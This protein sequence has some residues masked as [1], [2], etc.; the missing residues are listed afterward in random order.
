MWEL[1]N[2]QYCFNL[3]GSDFSKMGCPGMMLV[4][5]EF[6]SYKD[7]QGITFNQSSNVIKTLCF[8]AISLKKEDKD[9]GN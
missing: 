6:S 2:Y 7:H 4:L 1:G 5:L 8:I 9:R 3:Q